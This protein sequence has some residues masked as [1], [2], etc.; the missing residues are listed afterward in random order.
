[1]ATQAVSLAAGVDVANLDHAHN[2]SIG[3]SV[4]GTTAAATNVQPTI[5]LNKMI[6]I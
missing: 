4:T 6:A 1:M 3:V 2:L 5:I